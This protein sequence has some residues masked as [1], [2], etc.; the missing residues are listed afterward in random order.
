L[1]GSRSV[2]TSGT[3][4]ISGTQASGSLFFSN[5]APVLVRV[6]SGTLFTAH[7]GVQIRLVRSI[8]IPAGGTGS[9]PGVAIEDGQSG[10]LAPNALNAPCCLNLMVTVSNPAAFSGGSDARVTHLVAQSDLDGVRAALVPGLQQQVGQLLDA[11]LASGEALAGTPA[12]TINVTSDSPV[13]S[14]ATQANVTVSVSAS[15]LVYSTR[16]VGGLAH[17]LLSNEA[18]QT[19]GT[20]YQLHSGLTINPPRLEQQGNAGQLYLSVTVSGLWIYNL[21]AN[22]EH[23]WRQAI[24]GASATL[25]QN[26]LGTRPGIHAVRIVLPFGTDHLPTDDGQ[27]VFVV[28]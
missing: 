5:G 27:I 4:S 23:Q 6:A 20:G 17:Q 12:Y 10:N 19:L 21:T 2:A 9:A 14:Q 25:A 8:I 13:G 28:E 22:I 18:V 11:R 3:R 7:N 15:A 16:V 24:K 1:S 26:Y